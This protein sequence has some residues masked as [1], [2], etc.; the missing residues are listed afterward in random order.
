[1][2]W[3]KKPSDVSASRVDAL[4]KRTESLEKACKALLD[5]LAELEEKHVRLR[6]KVYA[7]KMHR[8]EDE[9]AQTPKPAEKMSRDELRRHLLHSGRFMPG[10]PARHD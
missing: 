10:R 9:D 6:G 4:E 5:D 3:R 7:H 1:M 2:F 8:A